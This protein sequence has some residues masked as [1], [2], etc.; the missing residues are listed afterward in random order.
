VDVPVARVGEKAKFRLYPEVELAYS[1]A[2]DAR[3]IVR[4]R[5]VVEKRREDIPR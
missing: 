2:P 3:M 4:V 1:R 5:N